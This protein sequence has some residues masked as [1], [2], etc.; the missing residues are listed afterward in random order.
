MKTKQSVLKLWMAVI[1]FS[2][3][4]QAHESQ[5]NNANTHAPIGVMGDHTHNKGEF[6]MSYRF[7]NMAMSGVG[8]GSRDLSTSQVLESYMMAPIEMDMSMHMLGFMYAPSDRWTVMAMINHAEKKMTMENRMGMRFHTETSGSSDSRLGALY[9][10]KNWGQSRLHLNLGLSIPTGSI[11]TKG[12]TPMGDDSI[13]PYGMRL[14][15]G[16]YDVNLGLTWNLYRES[17]AFGAQIMGTFRTGKNDADYRL[18]HESQLNVWASKNISNSWSF[19]A[20]LEAKNKQSIKGSDARLMMAQNMSMTPAANADFSGGNWFNLGL[21]LNF[22]S[23]AS[24]AFNGHRLALE[25]KLPLLEDLAGIQMQSDGM[26]NLG[27]QKSF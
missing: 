18:G 17:H 13:L 20:R 12:D 9:R 6:M 4:A 23:N 15:S 1:A 10:I 22:I 26:W 21:G 3:T 19:S 11:N 5:Q 8:S 25:Y 24:N 16:T 2:M 27:W 14:G 7:M